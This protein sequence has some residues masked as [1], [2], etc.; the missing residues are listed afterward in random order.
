MEQRKRV[1]SAED[2]ENLNEKLFD[3]IQLKLKKDFDKEIID[4]NVT[5]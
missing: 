3:N 5:I 4:F 1:R 2:Q